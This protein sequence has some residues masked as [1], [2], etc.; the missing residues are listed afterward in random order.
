MDGASH[1][2][3][4][5]PSKQLWLLLRANIY[6]FIMGWK[7]WYWENKTFMHSS[8]WSQPRS[9]CSCVAAWLSDLQLGQFLFTS[10]QNHTESKRLLAFTLP[11]GSQ[12]FYICGNKWD[13]LQRSR[14]RSKSNLIQRRKKKQEDWVSV[15]QS[16]AEALKPDF[17]LVQAHPSEFRVPE[18]SFSPFSCLEL[19]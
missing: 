11:L 8:T 17:S 16:R 13:H 5:Q 19:L 14:S 6:S 4:S 18:I 3:L 9:C 10:S 15:V 7:E 1:L 12:V 2:F